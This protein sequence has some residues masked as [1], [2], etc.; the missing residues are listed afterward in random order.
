MPYSLLNVTFFSLAA[1]VSVAFSADSISG[2]DNS[3]GCNR[4]LDDRK[5]TLLSPSSLSIPGI[6]RRKH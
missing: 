6:E 2:D 1:P 4:T 5:K 3:N